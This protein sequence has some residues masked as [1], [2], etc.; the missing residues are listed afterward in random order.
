MQER[1]LINSLIFFLIL[2]FS[3]IY[4]SV[5]IEIVSAKY[6]DGRLYAGF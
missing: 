6:G 5:K 4:A 2:L 1:I 3:N